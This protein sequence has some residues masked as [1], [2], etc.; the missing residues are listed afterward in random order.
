MVRKLLTEYGSELISLL[1]DMA[2]W[3]MMGFLIA[4]VLHVFFPEGKVNR[5]IGRSNTRS[6]VGAA[7]LGVPLPL[8]SC[9]VIPAGVSLYKNGASKGSAVSFLIST[10]QTGVDSIMVTYSML[11][12]PFAVLRPV[13]A[14]I[15][16]I[17]GGIFT[18]LRD[19]TDGTPFQE[20]TRGVQQRQGRKRKAISDILKYAYVDFLQDIAKWIIIGL[21]IAALIAVIIPDDFFTGTIKNDLLGMVIILG[22]SIPVYVCATSSVPIAAVLMMKGLSPGA[23]LVLLMAGP[24][25]NAATIT[26]IGKV[27]GKKV[28]M[29]Y[30][31]TLTIAALLFGMLINYLPRE[32]FTQALAGIHSGHR[33]ELLPY[34]I[35]L[36]SGMLLLL[37]I[38]HIYARKWLEKLFPR[39]QT[40]INSIPLAMQQYKYLVK[41]MNCSHCKMNVENSIRK[42]TGVKSVTADYQT[43][44]VIVDG[45]EVDPEKVR[46]AVEEVGYTYNGIEDL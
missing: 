40:N 34:W 42:V 43:G 17:A 26:V 2:P 1:L 10:P 37:L 38:V 25:S 18:N 23:A 24:A 16:G 5:L 7:L 44:E 27:L 46:S 36:T 20:D 6:V 3:L 39:L 22:L 8:C 15:T 32:W 29:I 28:L 30:L 35:K 41:G 12:L 13:I 33:H 45:S 4:G 19:R 21:L 31:A 9:G 14:F 11:G